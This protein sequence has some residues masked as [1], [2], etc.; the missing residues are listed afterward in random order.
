ML[1]KRRGRRTEGPHWY[2]RMHGEA[3]SRPAFSGGGDRGARSYRLRTMALLP[4]GRKLFS[5]DMPTYEAARVPK[6]WTPA[7]PIPDAA[8]FHGPLSLENSYILWTGMDHGHDLGTDWYMAAVSG[9]RVLKFR[10][11]AFATLESG[12]QIHHYVHCS[13]EFGAIVRECGNMVLTL[14]VQPQVSGKIR[15]T[16]YTMG[17]TAQFS[18]EFRSMGHE[19]CRAFE[20]M[21]ECKAHL[22]ARNKATAQ[23]KFSFVFEDKPVR[24]NAVLVKGPRRHQT[25]ADRYWRYQFNQTS[26]KRFFKPSKTTLKKARPPCTISRGVP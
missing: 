7:D 23:T 8:Q 17:G 1:T 4:T 15:V 21:R 14:G 5:K 12:A 25:V 10:K 20:F 9:G 16:A 18:K 6:N 2:A 22:L 19:E 13:G 3:S 24:G 26:L 11:T